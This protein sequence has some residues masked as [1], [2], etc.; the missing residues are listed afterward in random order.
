MAKK[1]LEKSGAE[2]CAGMVEIAGALKRFMDDP[3]FD[4]AWKQATKKGLRMGLTDIIPIYAELTPMLLGEDH[5][6]DTILI[7]SV[8]EGKSV[9]ELLAM[10]GTELL[11]DALKAFHEQ[12]KPFFLQLGLS[13]GGQQL[14][15]LSNTQS[16]DGEEG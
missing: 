14:S 15:H 5:I 7:L 13:V 9:S 1:L 12:V 11:A 16:S 2:I 8:I 10:N 3:V 4:K 6:K